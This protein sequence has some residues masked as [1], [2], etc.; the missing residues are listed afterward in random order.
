MNIDEIVEFTRENQLWFKSICKVFMEALGYSAVY[1]FVLSSKRPLIVVAQ[2]DLNVNWKTDL[3]MINDGLNK[4]SNRLP[5]VYENE[6]FYKI[7]DVHVYGKPFSIGDTPIYLMLFI[8]ML[9]EATSYKRNT[10]ILIKHLTR[11]YET[12]LRNI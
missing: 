9:S 1:L 10:I 12:N 6:V 3:Q 5:Y 7:F 4:E 8:C 2:P 11:I